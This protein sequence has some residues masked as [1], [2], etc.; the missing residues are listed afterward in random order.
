MLT[1]LQ[2]QVAQGALF[3]LDNIGNPPPNTNF[4]DFTDQAISDHLERHSYY[5]QPNRTA[6]SR[7]R[8]PVTS[9]W[10]RRYLRDLSTKAQGSFY[11]PKLAKDDNADKL[12][13]KGTTEGF[14]DDL[15]EKYGYNKATFSEA[16]LPGQ[17]W[18]P[19][20]R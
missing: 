15:L 11:E 13:R 14:S 4:R 5:S 20:L 1:E 17:S 12:F 10:L 9:V 16:D 19:T 7:N 6:G 18:S 8:K 2:I 3:L